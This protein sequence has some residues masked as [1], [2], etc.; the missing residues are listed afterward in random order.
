M[1]MNGTNAVYGCPP[2]QH[3]MSHSSPEYDTKLF[4]PSTDQQHHSYG[5]QPD[6]AEPATGHL[7]PHQIINESNGLSYTNLDTSAGQSSSGHQHYRHHYSSSNYYNQ[8]LE[9]DIHPDN[10]IAYHHHHHPG[11]YYHHHHQAMSRTSRTTMYQDSSA[12]GYQGGFA[13]HHSVQQ[14]CVQQMNGGA[15]V[16]PYQRPVQQQPVPTYKWM[17]IKRSLPKQPGE[18]SNYLLC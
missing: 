15:V 3:H 12:A 17:Q 6:P 11:G 10:N 13:E 18:Y 5:Y 7:P 16:A 1:M 14:E 4:Y 9:Y 2:V 8:T